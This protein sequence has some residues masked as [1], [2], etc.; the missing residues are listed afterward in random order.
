MSD[1]MQASSHLAHL[2]LT[3]RYAGPNV[4]IRMEGLTEAELKA[5]FDRDFAKYY[6]DCVLEIYGP[7]GVQTKGRG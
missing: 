7:K 1:R 2:E 4:V 3:V 6:W 5:Y